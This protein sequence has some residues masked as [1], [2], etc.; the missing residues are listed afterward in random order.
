LQN[1]TNVTKLK[2]PASTVFGA[3]KKLRCD[4]VYY[5]LVSSIYT[6]IKIKFL[7]DVTHKKSLVR[8]ND[9]SHSYIASA[10]IPLSLMK[11][12]S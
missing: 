7:R 1:I 12:S 2:F 5:N 6:K 3:I 10:Q 8:I 4:I 11:A 9:I